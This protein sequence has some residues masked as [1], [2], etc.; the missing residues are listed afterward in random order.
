[1]DRQLAP[2][3]QGDIDALIGLEDAFPVA[4]RITRRSWKYLLASPSARVVVARERGA[5]AGAAVLLLRSNSEVARLYSLSVAPDH[6]GKGLAS[7]LLKRVGDLAREAGADR[8]RLEVRASNGR[9]V[10][11]YSHADFAMIG[12]KANYYDDGEAAL[13]M[14]RSLVPEV[15]GTR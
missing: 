10:S 2:A 12:E 5:I 1:M 15:T 11:L 13:L 3:G 7:A 4:D 9:A 8:L 6:A 14:E